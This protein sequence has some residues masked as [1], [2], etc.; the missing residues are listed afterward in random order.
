MESLGMIE[1]RG[2]LAAIECADVMLKTADVSLVDKVLVGGGLVTVCVRG[3]VA[4]VKSAVDAGV[5]AV[6]ALGFELLNSNHIIPRPDSSVEVLL[7]SKKENDQSCNSNQENRCDNSFMEELDVEK[8]LETESKSFETCFATLDEVHKRE[9][10]KLAEIDGKKLT[11]ELKNMSVT[12]LRKLVREYDGIGLKGR[13]VSRARKEELL[14][15]LFNHYS[16]T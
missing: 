15:L 1:T 8:S 10:D 7:P 12:I 2:L 6:K 3:E 13:A 5:A 9:I 4:A 16:L 14:T 11:Q